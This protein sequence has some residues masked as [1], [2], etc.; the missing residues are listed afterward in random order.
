MKFFW[1]IK[2]L[3]V[4]MFLY[5][6]SGVFSAWA[7]DYPYLMN[8]SNQ[9]AIQFDSIAKVRYSNNRSTMYVVVGYVESDKRIVKMPLSLL[10]QEGDCDKNRDLIE[11]KGLEQQGF[12]LSDGSIFICGED[13]EK[14]KRERQMNVTLTYLIVMT[15]MLL[16]VLIGSFQKRNIFMGFLVFFYQPIS[17]QSLSVDTIGLYSCIE[18]QSAIEFYRYNNIAITRDDLELEDIPFLHPEDLVVAILNAK[19]NDWVDRYAVGSK[20]K[21]LYKNYSHY[22]SLSSIA[23]N[24]VMFELSHKVSFFYKN[25]RYWLV[26]YIVHDRIND[27]HLRAVANVVLEGDFYRLSSDPLP[28]SIV[29]SVNY[30]KVDFLEC[31]FTKCQ[32]AVFYT[33]R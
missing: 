28:S 15:P 20:V 23:D 12:V 13:D 32:D 29:Y 2:A 26:C 9:V 21:S 1:V 19:S 30:L 31:I 18:N 8:K 10:C 33:D 16:L 25:R 11:N 7:V 4:L 3:F 5:G 27:L 24:E 14:R 6:A 22:N 17:S